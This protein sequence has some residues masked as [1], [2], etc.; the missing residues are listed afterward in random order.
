MKNAFQKTEEL[1]RNY[2]TLSASGSASA[3]KMIQQ[4]ESALSHIRDDP[5]YDVI[6]LYY[7]GGR[8]RE[9][10]AARYETSVTTI[11]RQKARLV[12]K[13]AIILFP[14]EYIRM[15]HV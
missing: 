14:E 10:L 6:T 12:K 8:T 9:E 11:T 13:L 1:L 4:I 2:N 15:L 3:G 7:I 5:Y